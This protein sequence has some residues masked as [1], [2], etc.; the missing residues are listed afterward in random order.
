MTLRGIVELGSWLYIDDT[1]AKARND[2]C[3]GFHEGVFTSSHKCER[4]FFLETGLFSFRVA[5]KKADKDNPMVS[6]IYSAET[7]IYSS[8]TYQECGG[9]QASRRPRNWYVILVSRSHFYYGR[10]YIH[11][12]RGWYQ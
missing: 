6:L 5:S 1:V 3:S 12:I 8:L 10:N 7:I 11:S 2:R 9:I 4:V